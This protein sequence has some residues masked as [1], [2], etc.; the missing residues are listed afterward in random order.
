[1]R[2]RS[3]TTTTAWASA[4][5]P[6]ACSPPAPRSSS[7]RCGALLPGT[8]TSGTR[9]GG[10]RSF[11]GYVNVDYGSA[12]TNLILRAHSRRGGGLRRRRDRARSG[13]RGITLLPGNSCSPDYELL[14]SRY[15]HPVEPG[16]AARYRYRSALLPAQHRLQRPRHLDR[17]RARGPRSSGSSTTRTS[18]PRCSAGSATSIHDRLSD[19]GKLQ[20]PGGQPPGVLLS[21]K[22]ALI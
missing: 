4:G 1:M 2:S 14:G 13:H 5:S 18:G 20:A 6:T 7:P 8:S 22:A 12:A 10:P 19:P 15:P 17:E 11:G 9:N 16:A 21:L 3:T